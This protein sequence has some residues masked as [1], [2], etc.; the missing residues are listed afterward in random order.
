[1]LGRGLRLR[2][3]K[4]RVQCKVNK[5]R[6]LRRRT[7]VMQSCMIFHPFCRIFA[8]FHGFI[9]LNCSFGKGYGVDL[10]RGCHFLLFLFFYFFCELRGKFS[11]FLLWLHTFHRENKMI[12][13]MKIASSQC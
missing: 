11:G 9:R 8:E 12:C 1:M 5:E 3:I 10:I 7:G 13:R 4:W 2:G 6:S